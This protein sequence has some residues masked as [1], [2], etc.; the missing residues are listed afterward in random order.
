MVLYSKPS[1]HSNLNLQTH[2][3]APSLLPVST[4]LAKPVEETYATIGA[5]RGKCIPITRGGGIYQEQMKKTLEKLDTGAWVGNHFY[6][7][8]S[9]KLRTTAP[10]NCQRIIKLT[11]DKQSTISEFRGT[12]ERMLKL[13]VDVNR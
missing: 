2:L 1:N 7:H 12:G 3:F 4:L 8:I 13:L 9:E 6:S 5:K 10:V 11:T